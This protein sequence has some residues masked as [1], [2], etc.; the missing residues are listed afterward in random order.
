MAE[1]RAIGREICPGS[2]TYARDF[3]VRRLARNPRARCPV[4]GLSS[5]LTKR[6]T[7]W[8]HTRITASTVV[9]PSRQHL[10]QRQDSLM[11]QLRDLVPIAEREGMYDAADWIK[12]HLHD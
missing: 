1:R 2:G 7:I 4:C 10:P 11:E 3:E 8:R 6:G 12:G 9:K 5:A